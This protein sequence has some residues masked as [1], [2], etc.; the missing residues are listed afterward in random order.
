MHSASKK[1]NLVDVVRYRPPIS[2][3]RPVM[4]NGYAAVLLGVSLFGMNV[5]AR[6]L[7]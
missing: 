7:L 3:R 5:E 2:N 1:A 6:R 4:Q